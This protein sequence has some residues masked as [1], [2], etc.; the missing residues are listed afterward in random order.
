M[1]VN[2]PPCNKEAWRWIDGH[3]GLYL[4]SNQGNVFV[5][6]KCG[7]DGAVI[8]NQLQQN[9]YLTVDLTGADGKRHRHAVHR[10]VAKAFCF[11]YSPEKEV[12]HIDGNKVNNVASNLEW[13][14][15]SE[16]ALHSFN[17]LGNGHAKP[18]RRLFNDGQVRFIRSS[19]QSLRALGRLFGVSKETIRQIK[20]FDS[21]KEIGQ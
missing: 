9:G 20:N 3:E 10:L 12:N 21:Y 8:K 5:L 16:N 7:K 6:P 19:S 11:G 18:S 1:A 17:V 14:S 15:H 2:G 13:V 4:I